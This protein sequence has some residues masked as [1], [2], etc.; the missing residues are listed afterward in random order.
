MPKRRLLVIPGAQKAGTT[1]L[2]GLLLQHE[3]IH[4]LTPPLDVQWENNWKEP[5]FFSLTEEVVNQHL[6]WYLSLLGEEEGWY[7][8]AST[9]YLTAPK[10]PE[11]IRRL[12]LPIR[13]LAILRDPV[14]R[15]FSGYRH[16]RRE[17]PPADYR[18]FDEI[19]NFI[20]HHRGDGVAAAENEG[21]RRSITDI[22]QNYLR[23]TYL[24][25]LP[26]STIADLQDGLHVFKYLQQGMYSQRLQ[27]YWA[28]GSEVLTVGLETLSSNPSQ[29]SQRIFDHLDLE[30]RD[31]SLPHLNRG[32][33]SHSRWAKIVDQLGI[34][35]SPL[36]SI[37]RSI[38]SYPSAEKSLNEKTLQR[39]RQ[40]LRDEYQ[41]WEEHQPSLAEH[42]RYSL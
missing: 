9:S 21:I 30:Y 4:S 38:Q 7:V 10:A 22:N 29:V 14:E 36:M 33:S 5:H 16:M 28:A 8:D 19:I 23:A 34:L 3:S 39:T 32:G 25:N 42:W 27:P 31:V 20:W 6:D 24:R 40:L 37:V 26:A 15:A 18:S 2:F 41:Y 13:Y 17:A 11:L 1:S 35:A 12:P